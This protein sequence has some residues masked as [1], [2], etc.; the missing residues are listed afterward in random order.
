MTCKSLFKYYKPFSVYKLAVLHI[1][2]L[3]TSDEPDFL[4]PVMF[5]N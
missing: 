4:S 1:F 3:I 2:S 5:S